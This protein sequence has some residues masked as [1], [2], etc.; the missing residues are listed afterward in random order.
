MAKWLSV[1][2]IVCLA[3]GLWVA[4]ELTRPIEMSYP[5]FL[6]SKR[7]LRFARV[8]FTNWVRDGAI[9]LHN[10]D[11]FAWTNVRVELRVRSERGIDPVEC[12]SV[13]SVQ[14]RRFVRI[15]VERCM[16]TVDAS[17]VALAGLTLQADEGILSLHL[18]EP[19]MPFR[20]A[21]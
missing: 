7:P 10:L 15:P 12:P 19:G 4:R 5:H 21:R 8:D 2:V 16:G 14:A 6:A 9:T 1:A 20:V 13:S 3:A 17:W 18:G 11:T